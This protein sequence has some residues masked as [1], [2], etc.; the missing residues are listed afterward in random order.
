MSESE[1]EA[2]P[3]PSGVP[4]A[5]SSDPGLDGLE[6]S[7]DAVSDAASDET[8]LS[9]VP[10]NLRFQLGSGPGG[11]YG[12]IWQQWVGTDF[13]PDPSAWT[14]S[15]VPSNRLE[16]GG[17][18]T[19]VHHHYH[20]YAQ[21]H[22]HGS[23]RTSQ[24]HDQHRH[25]CAVCCRSDNVKNCEPEPSETTEPE[26]TRSLSE[27]LLKFP[28]PPGMLALAWESTQM[29]QESQ[30]PGNGQQGSVNNTTRTV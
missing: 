20:K 13:V 21:N 7:S 27:I 15:V 23:Q 30:D 6:V 12:F 25:G 4:D 2:P 26:P 24:N 10:N 29:Q 28:P 5:Q 22:F 3:S 19:V 17:N 11:A 9:W 1:A 14:Q 16:Y 18:F 8:S